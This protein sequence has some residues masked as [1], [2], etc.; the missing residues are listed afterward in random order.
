M[1]R[2]FISHKLFYDF[3][4]FE[5]GI[6]VVE[7]IVA[8]FIVGEF[9]GVEMLSAPLIARVLRPDDSNCGRRPRVISTSLIN[10]RNRELLATSNCSR[11]EMLRFP[12]SILST[13]RQDFEG[14]VPFSKVEDS[15]RFETLAC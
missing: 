9:N 10:E 3:R 11:A 12:S 8:G 5:T 6:I 2:N 13:S 15:S 14:D 7:F 4:G 1:G